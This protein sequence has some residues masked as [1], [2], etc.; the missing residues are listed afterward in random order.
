MSTPI[1]RQVQL[2]Q[3]IYNGQNTVASAGTAEALAASQILLSGVIVKA[4]AGNAGLVYVGDSSVA[5]T[6]GFELSAGEQVFIEVDNLASVY[7][8]SAENDDGVSYIGS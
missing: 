3:T 8:D 1:I 6:N 5:S 7:I 2:P 4:L